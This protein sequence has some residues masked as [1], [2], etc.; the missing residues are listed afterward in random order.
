M[1]KMHFHEWAK[2]IFKQGSDAEYGIAN[3]AWDAAVKAERESCAK[4]VEGFV[5]GRDDR[6]WVPGSLYDTL[7]IEA[8]A[9]IRK[10]SKME[11]PA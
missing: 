2:S 6:K 4:A 10:R 8:A 3:A 11:N 5:D 7:R 1:A 9:S